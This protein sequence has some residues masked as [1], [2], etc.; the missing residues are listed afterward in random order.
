MT[1]LL[2]LHG[3]FFSPIQLTLSKI[4][5]FTNKQ[6]HRERPEDLD[7]PAALADL[8]H[9]QRMQDNVDDM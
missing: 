2:L 3:C 1:F 9:Q 7:V 5:D 4:V 8:I 6:M